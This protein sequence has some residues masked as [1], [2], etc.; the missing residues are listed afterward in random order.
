MS[1]IISLYCLSHTLDMTR[2]PL[3]RLVC[4]ISSKSNNKKKRESDTINESTS[5]CTWMTNVGWASQPLLDSNQ[6][7]HQS[8]RRHRYS[9][10]F[11]SFM[12]RNATS[13][14]RVHLTY[15]DFVARF[16]RT[17][18]FPLFHWFTHTHTV[19]LTLTHMNNEWVNEWMLVTSEE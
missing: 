10:F 13:R 16:S 17:P 19:L 3:L 4:L 5:K 11:R 6:N 18:F 12:V 7:E 8:N 9:S 15:C 14:V 2:N 1:V